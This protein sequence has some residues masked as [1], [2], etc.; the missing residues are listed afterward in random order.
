[1]LPDFDGG[2]GD[3]GRRKHAP[4]PPTGLVT[5]EVGFKSGLRSKGNHKYSRRSVEGNQKTVV[6][7]FSLYF[8]LCIV[9][10]MLI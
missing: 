6:N 5:S 4:P 1:M 9:L 7:H 3:V 8:P 10:N 2:G